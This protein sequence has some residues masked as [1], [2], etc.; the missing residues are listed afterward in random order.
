MVNRTNL[1]IQ[2][3]SSRDKNVTTTITYVNPQATNAQLIALADALNALTS[4]SK[5]QYIKDTREVLA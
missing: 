3:K 2:A 5:T 1:I 4:N